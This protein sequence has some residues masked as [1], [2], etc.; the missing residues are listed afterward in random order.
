VERFRSSGESTE[1][2][3]ADGLRRLHKLC[4]GWQI[5]S[6][7][8]VWNCHGSG[9]PALS[10]LQWLTRRQDF[11]GIDRF[12]RWWQGAASAERLGYKTRNLRLPGRPV[13][14]PDDMFDAVISRFG[15]MFFPSP[16]EGV[17]EM[18]EC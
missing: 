17:R 13:P 11:F 10:L 6:Q 18:C 9:E 16:V 12:Q 3:S 2:S 7:Q 14:F 1:K 5:G 4:R 8:A 15:L